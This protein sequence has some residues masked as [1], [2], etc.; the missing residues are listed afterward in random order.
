MQGKAL[1]AVAASVLL[2]APSGC[3]SIDKSSSAA[4]STQGAAATP[5]TG[6][7]GAPTGPDLHESVKRV[8][9]ERQR[10]ADEETA[11]SGQAEPALAPSHHDSGGGAAQFRAPG[12]N[13]IQESGGEASASERKR[14][15]ASLH[16]YLD[17]HA[18]GRWAAACH[19]LSAT[20]VVGLERVGAM[21]QSAQ[22]S[23]GCPKALAALSRGLQP[24]VLR[25]GAQADVGSLRVNG[26]RGFVLYHGARGKDYAMPMVEE[27]GEWKVA[28]LAGAPLTR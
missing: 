17:S 14:A 26:D 27:G 20:L 10:R 9:K 24:R 12:D 16:G 1:A 28:A 11:S 18:A 2:V 15:A 6:S 8:Q 21:S 3:G 4:G 19:Y 13:S 5:S 25:E 23:T 7:P 22:G